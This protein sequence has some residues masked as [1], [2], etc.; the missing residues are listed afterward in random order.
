MKNKGAWLIGGIL[1]AIIGYGIY[2]KYQ[3][4]KLLD[5]TYSFQKF[6]II[7]AGLNNFQFKVELV[8]SNPSKVDFTIDDYDIN[9]QFQG[10]TLTTLTGTSVNLVVPANQSVALPLDVQFN[11]RLLSASVAQVFL[12]AFILNPTQ[13]QSTSIRYTGKVSGKF[14]AIGFKNIPIDYTY[15]M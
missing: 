4:E 5:M 1:A 8:L 12:D 15:T 3:A 9:I 11:P 10:S 6:K 7:N 13:T 2:L 14:G